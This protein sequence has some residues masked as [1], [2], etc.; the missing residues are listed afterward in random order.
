MRSPDAAQ[1]SELR[2]RAEG[3]AFPFDHATCMALLDEIDRLHEELFQRED[4]E[5]GALS[6]E[7]D[8]AVE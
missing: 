6:E 2:R 7:D 8:H 1:T 3:K 4:A 5:V